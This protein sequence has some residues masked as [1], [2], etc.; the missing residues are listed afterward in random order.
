[1]AE[2]VG[3]A[4]V[5]VVEIINKHAYY[6]MTML[7]GPLDATTWRILSLRIQETASSYRG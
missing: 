1:M 7:D 3:S 4:D 5:I 2:N 6:V